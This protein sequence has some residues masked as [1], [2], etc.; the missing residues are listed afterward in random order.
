MRAAV[1]REHG[2]PRSIRL[3]RVVLPFPRLL[4]AARYAESGQ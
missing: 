3:R 2:P 1:A 4:D